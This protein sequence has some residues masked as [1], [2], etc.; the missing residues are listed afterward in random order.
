MRKIIFQKTAYLIFS[1]IFAGQ[2]RAGVAIN[3]L[4]LRHAF[5]RGEEA[6]LLLQINNQSNKLL[7]GAE[8]NYSIA[9]VFKKQMGV[10]F[11][12][13][14]SKQVLIRFDTTFIKSGIYDI[15]ISLK[16][17]N[18]DEYI[19]S[20][21][22]VVK[23]A[24]NYNPDRLAV[25]LW[26]GGFGLGEYDKQNRQWHID[27][28][29]NV[30]RIDLPNL[31]DLEN[32]LCYDYKKPLPHQGI[33]KDFYRQLD[34]AL[35]NGWFLMLT[36][37]SGGFTEDVNVPDAK[38]KAL[39]KYGE[40]EYLSNPFHPDVA[41]RQNDINRRVIQAVSDYP[42]FKF[43]WFNTE[44]E[45]FLL[46]DVSLARKYLPEQLPAATKHE[47][48]LPGVI[49]D[50]DEGYLKCIYKYKWGD[51][52][53]AANKRVA[54]MVH[55]YRPDVTVFSD[56]Y[57]LT[58]F[59]D[60][61]TGLDAISTWSYTNP[62]AKYGLYVETLIAA[63]KPERQKIVPTITMLNYPGTIF[64]KDKGWTLMGPG[65]LV[66][67]CWLNF[68]RRCDVLGIYYSSECLP[69]T[70]NPEQKEPYQKFPAS[71]EAL[72]KFTSNVAVP[73]G[74]LLK[75]LKTSHRRVAVLSSQ[76]SR[77][78][79]YSPIYMSTYYDPYQVYEFYILLAMNQI[80]AD[81][82]FDETIKLYGLED[83]DVLVLPKCETLLQSVYEAIVAFQSRG[84]LIIADQYLRA[85][86]DNIIRFDFDFT[87]RDKVNADAIASGQTFAIWNDHLDVQK[88]ELRNIKG[89]T[90]ED[91]QLIMERYAKI[92]GDTLKDKIKRRFSCSSPR[93]LINV[94][95]NANAYYIFMVNDNRTQTDRLKEF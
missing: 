69:L 25:W 67:N 33:S 75:H 46:D 90:A 10:S 60:R 84:G 72:K 7:N 9:N 39:H 86:L 24:K 43:C 82:I 92:L 42:N 45:D 28:G 21:R 78:Y 80:E 8:L 68:S 94:L 61:C 88:A 17:K 58:S 57:R 20:S 91:D 32:L 50:T 65:R 51:G 79:P 27:K 55:K 47:F 76:S 93:V 2:L 87:Y 64:P 18:E 29:F 54:D 11:E 53:V 38:F 26:G 59:Y 89:I 41:Q 85:P 22:V 36:A 83:Y 70:T 74:A 62:D 4:S 35:Y 23:I 30:A 73:Y 14:E 44:I 19:V 81:I 5:I 52:L 1:F 31:T 63:A 12:P 34:D 16:A 3:D 13:N 15:I 95:E 37:V 66:E 71:F 6:R 48:I 40:R 49:R 77:I 56:P